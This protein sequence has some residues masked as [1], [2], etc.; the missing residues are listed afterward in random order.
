MHQITPG[1]IVIGIG[2]LAL[3]NRLYLLLKFLYTYIKPSSIM[4]YKTDGAYAVVTGA[5]DGIGKAIAL[6]LACKGFNLVL[7]GRD[8]SKLEA[9]NRK[10]LEI[11][12]ALEVRLLIHDSSLNNLPDISAIKNLPITVLVNNVGI[13]PIKAFSQFSKSEIDATINAN[14]L[15]PTHLTN[16]LIPFFFGPALILNISSYAGIYP[17]PYLAVY[18]ATKAYNN[19][20]SKSLSVELENVET[21]SIL[22]GSVHT[23][24]NKKQISFLR[25]SSEVFA[26]KV[27]GV[28]GCGKKSVIPYW[29]HAV[30][31]Y[32]IS[33]L[34][35]RMMDRAMKNAMQQ[36]MKIN[37]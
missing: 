36:E 19:A 1:Y 2:L 32:L 17:P 7:H 29:P 12:P 15:F 13:G 5:T 33:L 24:S 10:A 3:T 31:T 30:Q 9:V 8:V 23:G 27:L 25:P 14:I 20:F 18:A 4:K 16:N 28:V 6:A 11:N 21:I 34:P 35:E 26:K 22:T 37:S